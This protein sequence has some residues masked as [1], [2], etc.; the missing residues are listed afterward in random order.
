[1][2]IVRLLICRTCWFFSS[3]TEPALM[4][5]HKGTA[6]LSGQTM[7]LITAQ[8]W[9]DISLLTGLNVASVNQ[10]QSITGVKVPPC[11]PQL[12]A[13][14]LTCVLCSCAICTLTC[15]IS[16]YTST[17]RSHPLKLKRKP[18]I[19]ATLIAWLPARLTNKLVVKVQSGHD[20]T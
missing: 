19:P 13:L 14:S 12:E 8:R 3:S 5:N 17:N 18:L 9:L 15:Y 6:K 11:E 2:N 7:L 20:I 10:E 1:M 4:S 16:C